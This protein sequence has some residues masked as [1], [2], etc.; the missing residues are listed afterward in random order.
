MPRYNYPHTAT[1]DQVDDYHGTLVPDPYRWLEDTHSTETKAWIEA[2]NKLTFEF[3]EQIPEREALRQRLT[4]LWDY[5]KAWAPLRKGARYFQLRNS[6]LQNQDV[7]YVMED[8]QGEARLLMDPNTLSRDG[9]VALTAWEASPDGGWLAYATSASGSDWLTWRVRAVDTGIDLPDCIEWSK[10]S[11]A[12][13]LP[14]SS[15]FYYSRYDS[16]TAGQEYQSANYYHKLYFHAINTPQSE[17]KLVYERPDEKEW[18]F[19]AQVS[20]EGRYLIIN[21]WQGTDVRNR[22]FYQDLHEGGPVVELI[23][24]QEAAYAFIGNDG[25]IFYL[26]TDLD[27]PRGRLIRVDIRQPDKAH[28]LTL[29]PESEDVIEAVKLVQDQFI[30]V[31]LHDAHHRLRCI[32]LDG[33]P[34]GE[35]PLP[36]LGS[37]VLLENWGFNA[38]RKDRELFFAF[39]SFAWPT[40]IYR[41]TLRQEGLET[42]FTPPIQFDFGP[43]VTRQ[44]WATSKDGTR[45]PMFLV[46]R[47]ELQAGPQPTLL[48]GYGGFAISIAPSFMI[49]RLVWLERGGVLAIANLRGGSEYGE[50]WHRAGMLENK[51]NVFD[52]LIG[53]A[54]Y[55]ISQ[56]LTRPDKLAIQGGSNGGLLVGACMTQRPELFGAALPAVGV[57]DMLRFH[58]FTI[59]WAWVS[60]YGSS[61]DPEQF[62]ILYAYSPLHNLKPGTAYPP[63][64]I[65]TADHDDR[66]VPGHSFKFAAALQAAQ[67]GDAP[68]LIRIQTKAGHGFGKP[69]TIIIEEQADL[70]AFLLQVLNLSGLQRA[71]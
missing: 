26:R 71:S 29:V 18:G 30:C 4:E 54:E 49:S 27:A 64:L 40:T 1:I 36:T 58:K 68:V 48:G 51:Q 32:G 45:V 11:G 10:F 16:P 14:D 3:L 9:T 44:V 46:H 28:W 2:Q 21:V 41:Y 20:D 23:S 15:G 57:M 35:I 13:W 7:L 19:G 55:L 67:G 24:E 25:P 65:T 5:P 59:G 52:D 8:F 22:M 43:Y 47:R 50:E 6:G 63:T 12:A 42:I 31:D 17:D 62:K 66:V 56:G 38:G 61:D 69:T 53:C 34:L 33:T 60:D 39:Q 37:L 70:W